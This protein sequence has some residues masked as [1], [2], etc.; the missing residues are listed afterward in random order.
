MVPDRVAFTVGV[1]TDAPTVSAAFNTNTEKLNAVF[2]ALKTA[3]VKTEELQTSNFGIASTDNE[4][5]KLPGYRVTNFVTV[6]REDVAK[7]GDLLQVAITAGANEAGDM[8]FFLAEPSKL[9]TGG[10][11]L[12]FKDARTKA[13]HLAAPSSKSL[14]EVIC[15]SDQGISQQFG[16]YVS[17][18][19]TVTAAAPMFAAR[20]QDFSFRVGAVF[21]LK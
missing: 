21:E 5:K 20:T 3:G 2:R 6:T 14:G 10:M 15:V 16:G 9:E 12:A 11:E 7:V 17:E 19:I 1:Q 13:E 4:G 8:R 18:E